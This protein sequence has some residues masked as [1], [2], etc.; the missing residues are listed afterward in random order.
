MLRH[1]EINSPDVTVEMEDQL[2]RGDYFLV[3]AGGNYVAQVKVIRCRSGR[4]GEIAE[5]S[6]SNCGAVELEVAVV[7]R[8]DTAEYMITAAGHAY[9]LPPPLDADTKLISRYD[10][11]DTLVTVPFCWPPLNL[12]L[13]SLRGQHATSYP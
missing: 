10:E 13:L 8:P 3:C 4:R 6:D 12:V 7:R 11:M 5:G 1:G 9:C 2:I